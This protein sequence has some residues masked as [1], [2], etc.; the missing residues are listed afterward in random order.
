VEGGL[1]SLFGGL[2]C[3]LVVL[4]IV[5]LIVGIVNMYVQTGD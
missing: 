4:T 2:C 3:C 5:L 1:G